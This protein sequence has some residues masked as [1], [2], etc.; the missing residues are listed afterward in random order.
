MNFVTSGTGSHLSRG[1]MQRELLLQ[2]SD[3]P[4]GVE[5]LDPVGARAGAGSCGSMWSG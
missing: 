2:K 3:S 5:G 4:A 1:N